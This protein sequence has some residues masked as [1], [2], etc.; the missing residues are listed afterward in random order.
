MYFH[1]S[2][3]WAIKARRDDLLKRR[4]GESVADSTRRLSRSNVM[5]QHHFEESQFTD[6]AKKKR[7]ITTAVPTLFNIPNPPHTLAVKRPAPTRRE[8]VT[9]K[10]KKRKENTPSMSKFTMIN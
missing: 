4:T 1:R 5:C 9:E 6:A 3:E 2:K 7:L 10:K 8:V